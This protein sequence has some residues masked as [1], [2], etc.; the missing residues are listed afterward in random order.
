MGVARAKQD[1]TAGAP[2]RAGPDGAH[3]LGHRT[4]TAIEFPHLSIAGGGSHEG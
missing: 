4:L 2:A 3:G 1:T